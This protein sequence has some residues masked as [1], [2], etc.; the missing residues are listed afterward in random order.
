MS[1]RIKRQLDVL[2]VLSTAKPKLRKAIVAN[3]D[4]ELVLALCEVIVNVLSGNVKIDYRQRQ[5]LKRYHT[6]LRK[7]IDRTKSIKQKKDLIVQQG[8]FLP[9][10]LV[11]ALSVIASLVSSA[12]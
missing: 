6:T 3:S 11:P 8:G 2:R 10:L 4:A 9:S 5:R 1:N 12:L 7:L